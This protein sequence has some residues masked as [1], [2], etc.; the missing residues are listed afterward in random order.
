MNNV[1]NL[2]KQLHTAFPKLVPSITLNKNNHLFVSF[3]D[4]GSPYKFYGYEI[5][6]KDLLRP[7]E[8]VISEIIILHTE[9]INDYETRKF[10]QLVM[11]IEEQM[12]TA[13]NYYGIKQFFPEQIIIN[14]E[15]S[16]ED[17]LR[18]FKKLAE[19]KKIIL[20]AKVISKKDNQ[21][22][23]EG[24]P[25]KLQK[26]SQEDDYVSLQAEMTYDWISSIKQI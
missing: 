17:I 19:D 3:C 22:V 24:S 11:H 7:I 5:S 9:Q 25:E 23:W 14:K 21:I 20:S 26:F 8:D 18:A 2:L 12:I 16:P 4:Q 1:L 10:N 13:Y 6:E 15:Y